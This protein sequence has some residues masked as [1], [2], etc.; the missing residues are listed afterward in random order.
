M[1]ALMDNNKQDTTLLAL[2]N[3]AVKVDN[4]ESKEALIAH[5]EKLCDHLDSAAEE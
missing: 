4:H 1:K 3:Q 2:I 5:W